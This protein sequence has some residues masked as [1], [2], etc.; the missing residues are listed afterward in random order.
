MIKEILQME[1]ELVRQIDEL[2]GDDRPSA[3]LRRRQLESDR[4]ELLATCKNLSAEEK[5][6]L[7][8]HPKRPKIDE[9]ID[10]LFTDFFE[11][12]GDRASSDDTSILG[13]IAM[14][15]GTPV[16][17]IGHR[18][19]N[20]LEENMA[21][22][23]GMPEPEGYRKA[24]RMMEQAE[25]FG[26]PIITFID[27]PGAYPGKEAEE[28]GQGEAIARNL[29]VMSGLHVPIIAV[30]TGEGSSGGALALGVA[31]RVLMLEHA[32][33][34]VLSP[35]GFASILWKDSSRRA[36]A[37]EVMKL[38]AQDLYRFHVIERIIPEP[39]GGAQANREELFRSVDE[40]LQKNLIDLTRMS[41][42]TLAQDR[43]DKFRK[44]GQP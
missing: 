33:Y 37:C 21:Y 10:A 24:L 1:E 18:K 19:G 40:A 8:R 16:T 5:V 7:A 6:F 23:F 41:S 4:Q 2:K 25:K 13:G 27:T 35:E 30:V 39:M 14:Y 12:K 20:T 38:T 36:E 44:I 26:R 28:H 29:M 31:N 11:Q 15:K 32:I 3:R 9:Y 42:N 43:Y 17:V 34:S 22:N